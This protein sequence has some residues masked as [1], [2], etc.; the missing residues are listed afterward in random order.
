MTTQ[1]TPEEVPVAY[2]R[3]IAVGLLDSARSVGHIST[4][5]HSKETIREGIAAP[6]WQMLAVAARLAWKLAARFGNG[7]LD[8]TEDPGTAARVLREVKSSVGWGTFHQTLPV[9]DSTLALFILRLASLHDDPRQQ[10]E[11]AY[12]W[13]VA[14]GDD[15]TR[16]A[17][18]ATVQLLYA[19]A[20]WSGSADFA[21]DTF[22]K[23][24]LAHEADQ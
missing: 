17:T 22:T 3:G 21:L 24:L 8:S 18:W 23:E 16:M 9:K 6:P 19:I 13:S 11:I 1:H 15:E 14:N 10:T 12:Q 5:E 4:C 2:V 7:H 20:M